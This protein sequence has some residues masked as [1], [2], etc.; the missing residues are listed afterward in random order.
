MIDKMRTISHK[1]L[2]YTK[3]PEMA[4]KEFPT[5]HYELDDNLLELYADGELVLFGPRVV[6][7]FIL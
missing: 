2:I 7:P 6:V 3:L 4:T 5:N 1:D